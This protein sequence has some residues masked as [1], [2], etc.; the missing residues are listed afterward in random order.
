MD[1]AL[2]YEF[3]RSVIR[4]TGAIVNVDKVLIHIQPQKI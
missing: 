1:Q 4:I 2:A 3:W